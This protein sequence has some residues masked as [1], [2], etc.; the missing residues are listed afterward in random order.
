VKTSTGE[1]QPVPGR[2][3]YRGGRVG[4]SPPRRMP[5]AATHTAEMPTTDT[6]EGHLWRG[7]FVAGAPR[8]TGACQLW[9]GR[10]GRVTA[11]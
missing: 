10:A 5:A 8:N 7:R 1:L 2:K 6:A 4:K 9:E 3:T 11:A